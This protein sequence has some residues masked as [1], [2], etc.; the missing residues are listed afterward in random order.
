LGA[1]GNVLPTIAYPK[2]KEYAEKAL[3]L[4]DELHHSHLAIGQVKLYFEWD[5]DGAGKAINRA[6]ELNPGSG[7]VHHVN[8]NY[9]NA[10]GK[11]TEG[12]AEIELSVRL[13]PLSLT[14]IH[15]LGYSYYMSERYQDALTQLDK[16]LE[17][18]PNYRA[19]VEL[20]GWVYLTLGDLEKAISELQK[21]QA[22][23]GS[24][25]K[26]ITALGIAYARAGRLDD[27]RQCL[28]KMLKRLEMDEKEMLDMEIFALYE[29]LGEL[30]K[31][32]PY[33]KKVVNVRSGG[34]LFLRSNPAFKPIL[35]NPRVLELLE[36]TGLDW[37]I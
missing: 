10:V 9:L 27:T 20:K 24:E 23:T 3:Q 8:G 12:V 1:R 32:L 18:D 11:L 14:S 22:M 7:W 26:G 13:D 33:L 16:V 25:Y 21:Y 4:D 2:A 29:S 35:Q 19:A 17:M 34:L 15:Y 31:G 28:E 36:K 30:E 37:T 6:I 5:W